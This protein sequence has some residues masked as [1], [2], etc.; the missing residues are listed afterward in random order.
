MSP[1]EA[2]RSAGQSLAAHK[3]RSALTMLGMIFG[4]GAVIAMLSIGAGAEREA[5]GMI[6]RLGLANVLV[7]AKTFG[8][9]E[10]YQVRKKSPGLSLRDAAAIAEAV[11]GVEVVVPRVAIDPYKVLSATGKADATVHGVSWRHAELAGLAVEEGRFLDPLDEETHAQVCVIGPGVRRDLFGYG[12]A[13]GK[14]LKVNDVWLEVVGVLA[15]TGGG[16]SFQGVAVGSA[17]REIYLP[18]TTAQRKFEHPALASPSTSSSCTWRTALRPSR[19]RPRSRACSPAS[20][21]APRT[22]RSSSPRPCS[23]RASAPSACSTSSWG[24]SPAS[25]SWSA[26]S[27]S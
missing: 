25:R 21:A 20:T 9:E 3:L 4:V 24:R 8:D 26:A 2:V 13:L 15:P 7:R 10:L 19:P 27:A 12:E 23:S 5:L 18:V 1:R 14:T 6:E 17:A 22:T 11:P 16:E